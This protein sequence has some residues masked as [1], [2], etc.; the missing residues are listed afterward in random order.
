MATE[1]PKWSSFVSNF[2]V[3]NRLPSDLAILKPLKQ[4]SNIIFSLKNHEEI[5]ISVIWSFSDIKN[6]SFIFRLQCISK[7]V[8]TGATS[9]GK[10]MM[11][12][13][14]SLDIPTNLSSSFNNLTPLMMSPMTPVITKSS[15]DIGIKKEQNN[16]H[17]PHRN[18]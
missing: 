13:T 12:N 3:A 16:F 10:T 4:R 7:K 18:Q 15:G 9:K 14:S 2:Y 1:L 17:F 11:I 8:E 6:Q 5:G